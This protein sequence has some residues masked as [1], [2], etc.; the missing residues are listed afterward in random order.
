M[1]PLPITAPA[2][3]PPTPPMVAPLAALLHPSF[4]LLSAGAG[5]TSPFPLPAPAVVPPVLLEGAVDV[6]TGVGV[7]TNT[8]GELV[9]LVLVQVVFQ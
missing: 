4:L 5:T 1:A 7:S 9:L 2:T 6:P 8:G 3:A